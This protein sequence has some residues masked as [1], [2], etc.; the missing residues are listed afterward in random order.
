MRLPA[1]PSET[2]KLAATRGRMP[3]MTNS[4]V[5]MAN[6][7]SVSIQICNG[8]LSCLNMRFAPVGGHD[9]VRPVSPLHGGWRRRESARGETS[10]RHEGIRGA[11]PFTWGAETPLH[12]TWQGLQH[13][14]RP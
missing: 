3:A 6:A 2:C 9:C 14:A 1:R 8:N 12:L 7:D 11:I 5:P 4:A 13:G 10:C